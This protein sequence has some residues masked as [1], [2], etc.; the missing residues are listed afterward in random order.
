MV[1]CSK[2]PDWA[3]F[4]LGGIVRLNEKNIAKLVIGV[5]TRWA[6][7]LYYSHTLRQMKR[8]EP[9]CWS[10]AHFIQFLVLL[11]SGLVA[12]IAGFTEPFL[13]SALILAHAFSVIIHHAKVELRIYIALLGGFIKSSRALCLS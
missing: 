12:V 7:I 2:N 5:L 1:I 13:G 10:D 6:F 3:V 9:I 4:V 8:N 11:A